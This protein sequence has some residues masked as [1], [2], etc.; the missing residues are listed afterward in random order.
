MLT[1]TKNP[2]ELRKTGIEVISETSWGTHFCNFYE[3]KQDMLDI[4]VPF[5]RSGLENN[6]YCVYIACSPVSVEDAERSLR[7]GIPL[8]DKYLAEGKIEVINHTEWYLKSGNFDP[9]DVF[10]CWDKKLNLALNGGFEGLRINGNAAW[11]ERRLW[12]SF[13][14]YENDLNHHIKD[15]NII[16]M[17]TYPMDKCF[18]ADVLDVAHVHKAAIAKRK[19]SWEIFESPDTKRSKADILKKNTQLQ[20]RVKIGTQQLKDASTDLEIVMLKKASTEE[21]LQRSNANLASIFEN[22][23]TGYLLLDTNMNIILFNKIASELAVS[24]FGRNYMN[25]ESMYNMLDEVSRQEFKSRCNSVLE[26]KQIK[27]EVDYHGFNNSVYWYD[28]RMF[29]IKIDEGKHIGICISAED[30]TDRKTR[31]L[32]KESITLDLIHRNKDLEQFSYMVSHN[33]RAPIANILGFS[34]L[35][36]QDKYE[37]SEVKNFIQ[38]I[39]S[40]AENLDEVIRDLNMI[41]QVKTESHAKKEEVRF[42]EILESIRKTLKNTIEKENAVII[43]N[44]EAA[45]TIICRRVY[46]YSIFLNLVS[47]SLKFH[48]TGV[49]PHIEITTLKKE[50]KLIIV[51]SDNGLGIDLK[52]YGGKVFGLYKRFHHDTEGKGMGLFMVK[53]QV[54]ILGGIIK[55]SS[56][57]NKGTEFTIELN[58]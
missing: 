17:C 24:S 23:D 15:K 43:E 32:E 22:T 41:L 33:L 35:A 6:E 36:L 49:L 46:L 50:D 8:F 12:D 3:T 34:K 38:Q 54:D 27:F 56:E 40:S 14:E 4:L 55:I 5:F 10:D 18:A 28:T 39:D 21:A 52:K 9:V 53:A 51:Y 1:K 37:E 13:L 57:V 30:I 31:E 44:F 20:D 16:V 45:E 25:G 42:A 26:G 2:N 47:N 11:L 48:N 7:K 58:Q 19:G 29:P